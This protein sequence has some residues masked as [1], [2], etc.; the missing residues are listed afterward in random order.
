VAVLL[1]PSE[2]FDRSGKHL[3]GAQA[4]RNRQLSRMGFKVME[5]RLED[6]AKLRVHPQQLHQILAKEYAKVTQK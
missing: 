1:H 2:H 4:M 5:F 6:L 3:I